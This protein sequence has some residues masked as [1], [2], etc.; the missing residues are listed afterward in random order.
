MRIL[1][2][3]I[4][5][6]YI[7]TLLIILM[8]FSIMMIVVEV[9]DRMPSL[10]RRGA[11]MPDMISYFLL[12]LPYL[13]LLTSP[14][15]V[16]LTGLFLMNNLSRYNESIA[17]RGAGISILRMVTPLFWLGLLISIIVMA[18]GEFV[19]PVTEEYRQYVYA[20]KIKLQKLE[21]KKMR[22]QIYYLGKDNHLYYIG[23]FDGYRNTLKTIDIT[24]FDPDNGMILKKIT[25]V[26]AVWEDEGWNL[27]NCYI[28]TFQDNKLSSIIYYPSTIMAEVDVT[29]QDFIIS[30]KKPLSMNFF[31]LK[32]YINRL[33]KIGEDVEKELV[34][35]NMKISFPFANLIILLFSVPLISASNR[36]RGRG[37]M[38]GLGL[39]VCFLYLSTLRISQSLGYNGILSPV[40]AAWLPNILFLA[41]GCYFVIKAEI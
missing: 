15:V 18:L 35:L 21:D 28:R 41:I 9:S 14:I 30:A 16:L 20:E 37:L 40:M 10:I 29:P 24:H 36:S 2:K 4:L 17:I 5:R 27:Q 3:Y 33:Q 34:D 8:A 1:D 19:L 12:R 23:F 31:E 38:F 7:K 39:L 32:N 13:F 25:A 22:S 26:S 11:A 6:E